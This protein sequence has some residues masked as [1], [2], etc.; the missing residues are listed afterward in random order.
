MK[1]P[2]SFL[3]SFKKREIVFH[4]AIPYGQHIFPIEEASIANRSWIKNCL[5]WF[6]DYAKKAHPSQHLRSPHRCPG[7]KAIGNTGFI[8]KAHRD[9]I[10]ET[11]GDGKTVQFWDNTDMPRDQQN[12][13]GIFEPELFGDHL[14]KAKPLG[15]IR[16]VL[17]IDLPWMITAPKDIVFI[18][19]GVPYNDDNRFQITPGLLDPLYACQLNAVMWWMVPKGIETIKRG[20]PLIQLIPIKRQKVYDSWRMQSASKEMMD[21]VNITTYAVASVQLANYSHLKEASN[22]LFYEDSSSR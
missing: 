12:D 9:V 7:I 20:T 3:S 16:S 21:K 5:E 19:M 15:A 18:V 2:F 22:Q 11:T 4:C 10:I 17:K 6:K 8:A 13:T 14:E 1:C